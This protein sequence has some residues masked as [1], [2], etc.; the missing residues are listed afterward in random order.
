[1][2][3]TQHQLICHA[4]TLLR[5]QRT[6]VNRFKIVSVFSYH[7]HLFHSKNVC[8]QGRGGGIHVLKETS[9]CVSYNKIA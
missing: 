2:N 9:A 6:A 8:P 1:M 5:K 4:S 3:I 7:R